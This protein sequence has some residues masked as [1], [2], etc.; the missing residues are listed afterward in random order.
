MEVRV[1][2]IGDVVG[3]AGMEFLIETLPQLRQ[4]YP[5]DILIVN[6]ENVVNGKGLSAKE[7]EAMFTAGVDVITTGNHIWENWK[8]RPLLSKEP[9][10]LRPYNYPPRNPGRGYIITATAAG[11]PYAVVQ[12]QGRVFLPPIDCPFRAIDSLLPRLQVQAAVVILDFHAEAT[13]E[14]QAMGWH[15]DGRVSLIVGTHTHIQ[16]ADARIL[17]KGTGYIT[18]VGMT[19]SYHSVIGMRKDVALRRFLLQT[20]FK[21]EVATEDLHI[22]GVYATVERESGKTLQ[23][24]SFIYPPL[25]KQQVPQS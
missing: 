20:A 12:L 23:I 14:K 6:G 3:R 21:Y 13:A 7:A 22:G 2:F 19:G 18:D 24:E 15:L 11:V 4:R 16:T 5:W 8:A 25:Q 10:V 1:L 17:P 9:R